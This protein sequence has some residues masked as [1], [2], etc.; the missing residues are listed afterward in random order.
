MGSLL[1]FVMIGLAAGW[2]AGQFVRGNGGLGVAGDIAAGA[3]G[4]LFGGVM[5]IMLDAPAGSG[6]LGSL[7]I[8]TIGAAIFSMVLRQLKRA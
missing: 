5:F 6:L 1:W 2:L 4:G 3:M 8:A 7:I